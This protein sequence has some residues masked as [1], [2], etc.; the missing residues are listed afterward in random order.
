MKARIKINREV[1]EKFHPQLKLAFILAE[2]IDNFSK[3][4][5]ARHLLEEAEQYVHLTFHKETIKNHYL[6]S[7]WAVAQAEFGEEAR[8]YQTSVEKLLEKVLARKK[9]KASDTLTNLVSYLS[10]KH[11]LPAAV[12]DLDKV[13]GDLVFSLASGREKK[14][15]LG[16]ITAGDLYY[17]DGRN[18]LGTKLDYWK[19]RR[20]AL[21][22]K[23]K[24]ALIHIEA[25]PPVTPGQLK[26]IIIS[27]EAL[28]R[29]FCGGQT[30][31]MVL[32]KRKREGKV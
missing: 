9:I 23:T 11:L 26:E 5:E 7:P 14:G 31:V 10:L 21:S 2:N 16:K 12:D 32:S 13:Q 24:N 4:K 25:L 18:I 17:H 20:T 19:S 30:R 3:L 1:F 22:R 27:T 8:H 29:S 28:V 15:F 6:I